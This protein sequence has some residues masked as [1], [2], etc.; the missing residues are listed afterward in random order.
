MVKTRINSNLIRRINAVRVFHNIRTDPGLS[1]QALS[2]VTGIDLATISIIVAALEADGIVRREIAAR[3]GRSGR[4]TSNL[5]INADAGVLAGISFET[6]KIQIVIATLAGERLGALQ[7][8]GSVESDRAVAAAKSGLLALLKQV[9]VKRKSLVGVG[10]GVPGLVA[11]DGMLVLAPN[12]GWHDFDLAQILSAGIGVPVQVENDIKAAAMAEHLFGGSKDVADFVYI[13]GRSGIGG[14][15]YLGGGLYRGPRGLA[16]EIGHM[17][18]V[19]FGRPCA[20][21]AFGCFEAYVS[22]RAIITRLA[23]LGL[24]FTS[25]DGVQAAAASGNAAV[26]GVLDDVGVHLGLGLASLANLL[27]PQ[28][29]VLGGSLASLASFL[30]PASKITYESNALAVIRRNVEIV[31]SPLGEFAIPM[32]GIALALQH[33]LAEPPAQIMTIRRT[34]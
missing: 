13:A 34:S 17:K 23:E 14:G 21:G 10:V 27:T 18:L 20:C 12:L 30:L 31:T 24:H 26:R 33:F 2:N 22:E 15:L 28:R 29:I 25:A 5:F 32:G 1:P 11:L 4:P 6:D 8:T 9:G 16:G 3:T 19:P 7:I